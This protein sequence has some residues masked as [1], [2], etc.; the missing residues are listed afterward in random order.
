MTKAKVEVQES[1]EYDNFIGKKNEDEKVKSI[2]TFMGVEEPDPEKNLEE[3]KKHWHGM[4]EFKQEDQL[5]AKKLIINFRTEED[6]K[7]FSEL[8]MKHVD[9]SLDISDKTKS[10]WYP[11]R[12]KENISVLR[13]VEEDTN[14]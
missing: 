3:W 11:K 4:P 10:F 14:D 12:E 9:T 7:T 1:T 6:F 13:W 8:Y 5:P 2:F